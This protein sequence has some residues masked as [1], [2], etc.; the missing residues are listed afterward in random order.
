MAAASRAEGRA[1]APR[2]RDRR[3]RIGTCRGL[4]REQQRRQQRA[5]VCQPVSSSWCLQQGSLRLEHRFLGGTSAG[6]PAP[7]WWRRR[8]PTSS[9]R[10]PSYARGP[11]THTD[12]TALRR[13][14]D[15]TRTRPKQVLLATRRGARG[16]TPPPRR[17]AIPRSVASVPGA[18]AWRGRSC[19]CSAP[20]RR[21]TRARCCS[22]PRG[23][24]RRPS[25]PP[26]RR[27]DRTFPRATPAAPS[28]A[29]GAGVR[30]GARRREPVLGESATPRR[31][32]PKGGENGGAA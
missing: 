6:T 11:R 18:P 10:A 8:G 24:R 4:K 27:P 29:F 22:P 13:G 21:G 14:I 20:R 2:A 3:C 19:P 15:R 31:C 26:R 12:L 1:A 30:R 23:T 16:G 17:G 7:P 28:R 9:P 5:G 25:A 32:A